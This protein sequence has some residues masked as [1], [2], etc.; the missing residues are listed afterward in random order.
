MSLVP[1]TLNTPSIGGFQIFQNR[2]T[3][4]SSE[5]LWSGPVSG[6]GMEDGAAEAEC[7]GMEDGAAEAE[8]EF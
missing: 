1:W 4:S 6:K 2:K 3:T 7:K 5:I 8:F